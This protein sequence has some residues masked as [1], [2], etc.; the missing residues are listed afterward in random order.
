MGLLAFVV[1]GVLLFVNREDD[2]H[3]VTMAA[4]EELAV[5]LDTHYAKEGSLPLDLVALGGVETCYPGGVCPRDAWGSLLEYR[6]V[7]AQAGTFRLRSLGPDRKA[8]TGDDVVWPV[9]EVWE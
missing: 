9:G 2:P 8:D 7:D 3:E 4:L 1:V 6:P 5:H